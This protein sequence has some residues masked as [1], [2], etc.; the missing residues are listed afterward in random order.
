MET[1]AAIVVGLVA[2]VGLALWADMVEENRR[3]RPERVR[4]AL[5]KMADDYGFSDEQRQRLLAAHERNNRE[6]G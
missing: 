5:I 2:L 3:T 6:E 1:V 4:Q